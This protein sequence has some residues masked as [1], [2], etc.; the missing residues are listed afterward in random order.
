MFI[1]QAVFWLLMFP[2]ATVAIFS[3]G[4]VG[5][6]FG[7]LEDIGARGAVRLYWLLNAIPTERMRRW[8]DKP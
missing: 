7:L 2:S 4:L 3:I 1:R 5:M 8:A 6:V